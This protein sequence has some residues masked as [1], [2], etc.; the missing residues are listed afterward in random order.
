[1][2]HEYSFG[3][4]DS[5]IEAKPTQPFTARDNLTH[6]Y[7]TI[8]LFSDYQV[9]IKPEVMARYVSYCEKVV[10]QA[11]TSSASEL[12]INYI[13]GVQ[14]IVIHD[15]FVNR[16][17]KQIDKQ[18][19]CH[20][21]IEQT[22]RFQGEERF[23]GYKTLTLLLDDIRLDDEVTVSY[24]L[25]GVDPAAKG[26]HA[27]WINT[28]DDTI[29]Q[30]RRY[31]LIVPSDKEIYYRNFGT[32]LKPDINKDKK[33]GS[34]S[35]SW[36]FTPTPAAPYEEDIPG[37]FEVHPYVEITDYKN[38][39]EVV[40]DIAEY[41]KLPEQ[42]PEFLTEKVAAIKADHAELADQVVACLKYV[43]NEIRYLSLDE[44]HLTYKPNTLDTIIA[45]G[46]GDCKDKT[47]MLVTLLRM[48]GVETYPSLISMRNPFLPVESLPT[49]RLFD[50]I[51]VYALINSKPYWL[52]STASS[53]VNKLDVRGQVNQGY[54]L[55]LKSGVNGLEKLPPEEQGEISTMDTYDFTSGFKG[56]YTLSVESRY[57]VKSAEYMRWRLT[58]S[59]LS[60]LTKDYLDFYRHYYPKIEVAEDVTFEDDLDKNI[61]IIRESYVLPDMEALE[62]IDEDILIRALT[63]TSRLKRPNVSQRAFPWSIYYP[64]KARNTIRVLLSNYEPESKR[65]LSAVECANFRLTNEKIDETNLICRVYE[66]ES[67]K[68]HVTPEEMETY[69]EKISQAQDICYFWVSKQILK[70]S[71]KQKLSSWFNYVWIGVAIAMAARGLLRFL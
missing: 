62:I 52:D 15:L 48:L 30:W 13:P 44:P 60:A 40:D 33:S 19:S 63:T 23:E 24:T 59:T 67:L 6:Q 46:F 37:W 68:D 50:H 61:L 29:G 65:G 70:P 66:Y 69:E 28:S 14:H 18:K 35:Y 51:I 38:W 25:F 58:Q 2:K 21:R 53:D 3:P 55:V 36:L 7:G 43:Q 42:P 54:A 26:H 27:G 1:M 71:W 17:G 45:N 9:N 12:K 32:D 20:I 10:T 4:A 8:F 22:E 39:S 31:K 56:P 49:F 57:S 16:N 47:Y 41:Y 34:T 5:W 64:E 11:G